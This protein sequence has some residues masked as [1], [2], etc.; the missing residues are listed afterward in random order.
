MSD[1]E[2]ANIKKTSRDFGMIIAVYAAYVISKG[3]AEDADDDEKEYYYFLAYLNRRVYSE[4]FTYIPSTETARTLQSPAASSKFINDIFELG[5]YILDPS[6]WD[7]VYKKGKRKGMHKI[8]KETKDVIPLLK[9]FD[10]T[11]SESL[12]WQEGNLR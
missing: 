7:D 12:A 2:K 6:S 1:F 3:L 5:G 9:Q 11:P 10:R 4:L 8:W